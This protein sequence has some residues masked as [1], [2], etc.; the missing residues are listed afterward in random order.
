MAKITLPTIARTS[1]VSLINS[2]FQRLA[3]ELN[4]K[5]F[6][7]NNPSGEPNTIITGIDMN[8]KR[9]YNLPRATA[10]NQAATLADVKAYAGTGGTPT[11]P[12]TWGGVVGTIQNQAD[13]INLLA[14]KQNV[15]PPNGNSANYLRGDMTW[16]TPP[17]GSGGAS[18]SWGTIPGNIVDQTDLRNLLAGKEPLLPVS[19]V[20]SYL[21]GDRTFAVLNKGAVGLSNVD[22]TAD[23]AKPVSAAQA[24]ALALK[25]NSIPTGNVGQYLSGDKTFKPLNKAAVGLGNVDN[26]PDMAKPVSTAALLALTA[27]EDAIAPG[28]A[29]QYWSGSKTW[30]DLP[31][32]SGDTSTAAMAMLTSISTYFRTQS[33]FLGI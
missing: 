2:N 29:L 31:A 1:D 7:R 16:G 18:V 9:I 20:G 6:Y 17:T 14:T 11:V 30:R 3:N 25:E 32:S 21:R 23:A 26:T 12:A 4:T 27:K 33:L 10:D 24:A 19:T 8:G 5:V 22:N 28:T 15:L 13:L